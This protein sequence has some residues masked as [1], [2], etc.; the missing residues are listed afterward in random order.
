MRQSLKKE[1]DQERM[2]RRKTYPVAQYQFDALQM[3]KPPEQLT[4]S[5]WAQEYR[6]LDAKSAAMPGAWN[7]NVTPYLTE[8]MDA[9]NHY[10]YEEIIFCKPTQ[11]GGTETLQNMVGYIVMQDPAP[12]MIVY[13]TD[14]LAKSISENRL[15]PMLKATPEMKKKFDENSSLLELQFDGMYLS[16]VGSNSPSGL[17]SKPIRFLMLDEVDKYPGASNKEA[18]PI[19]LARERTKTFHNKKIYMTSTPTLKTG[20]IWRAK[21]SA[22][23]EKHFLYLVLIVESI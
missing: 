10:E 23:I 6:I 7:N 15:Q 19:K 9:F 17:A 18:D 3:L 21:E 11:I 2:P 12:T 4:V 22:D 16:L 13:P 20:H 8:V 1:V 14:T 5:E